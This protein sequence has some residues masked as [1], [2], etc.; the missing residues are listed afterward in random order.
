[1][2]KTLVKKNIKIKKN[3]DKTTDYSGR[4]IRGYGDKTKISLLSFH[5]L[6]ILIL[7]GS[8]IYLY[9]QFII[10]GKQLNLVNK[11]IEDINRN[12]AEITNISG[13]ISEIEKKFNDEIS[14]LHDKIKTV[15][16][17]KH[18]KATAHLVALA[19]IYQLKLRIDTGDSFNRE[20]DAIK[21]LK[22]TDKQILDFINFVSVYSVTGIKTLNN[23]QTVYN[24]LIMSA[25]FEQNSFDRF[26]HSTSKVMQRIF[27]LFYGLIKIRKL[28]SGND[29]TV[30]AVLQKISF[31]LNNANLKSVIELLDIVQSKYDR[32]FKVI[33]QFA[34]N[35]RLK[36]RIDSE[37]STIIV[38]LLDNIYKLQIKD[39]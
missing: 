9:N 15:D 21:A 7:C 14:I 34:N 12:S 10:F 26:N 6:I 38:N 24:N 19:M 23:L 4:I 17:N 13:Q 33:E 1:M 25:V 18:G 28:N 31:E 8:V 20:I 11:N 39:N 30:D 27:N 16:N 36:H 32:A 22:L 2:A 35:I 37:I 5:N 29:D 3:T